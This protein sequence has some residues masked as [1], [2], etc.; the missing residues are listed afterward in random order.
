[1]AVES[2]LLRRLSCDTKSSLRP[3]FKQI[4]RASAREIHELALTD[5]SCAQDNFDTETNE[6]PWFA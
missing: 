5:A 3:L 2:D 1:M 6:L 4:Q